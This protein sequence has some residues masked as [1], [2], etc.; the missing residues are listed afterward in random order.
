[1]L[2]ADGAECTSSRQ[3]LVQ[4]FWLHAPGICGSIRIYTLYVHTVLYDINN[5][6]PMQDCF[7]YTHRDVV[8]M[9]AFTVFYQQLCTCHICDLGENAVERSTSQFSYCTDL[10]EITRCT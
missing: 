5:I 10:V 7:I 2:A 9:V 8:S 1:M 3:H 6:I 4:D